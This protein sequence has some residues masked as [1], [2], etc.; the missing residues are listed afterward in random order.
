MK[1][2]VL[3]S[4]NP[5]IA[6]DNYVKIAKYFENKSKKV[7]F[8]SFP[9]FAQMTVELEQKSY[10]PAFFAMIQASLKN[11]LH[12]KLYGKKNTVV[13]GN[14]Y[15]DEKF[16][17]IVSLDDLDSEVFDAYL[18]VFKN[19]DEMKEF[20][21]KVRIHDLY[22]PEDATLHL[23]TIDHANLFIFSTLFGEPEEHKAVE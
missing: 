22:T 23:P 7:N 13:I 1:I 14:V 4:I 5:V 10:I 19:D 3:T 16:D 20:G 17:H 11:P 12:S 18:E 8:L 9:F 15:K 21:E 2:L 6:V